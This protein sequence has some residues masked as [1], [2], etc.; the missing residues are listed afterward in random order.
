MCVVSLLARSSKT[1][2]TNPQG[3][4]AASKTTGTDNVPGATR[5][6]DIGGSTYNE[7]L[8]MYLAHPDILTYTI[9][10][11]PWTYAAAN[12]GPVHFVE[13]AETMR[14]ESICGG[15]ATYIDLITYTCSD[16]QTLAYNAWYMFHMG[17]FEGLSVMLGATVLAGDCPS[18][19]P[20]SVNWP[21]AKIGSRRIS[22]RC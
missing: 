17:T 1:I 20:L 3:G 22:I 6:G 11:R 12:F 14:F 4:A 10:G 18:A 19:Y 16:D 21:V 9:H 13:Y 2:L 8:T 7:T 5:S 15:K